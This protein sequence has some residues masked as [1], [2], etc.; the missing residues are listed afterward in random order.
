MYLMDQQGNTGSRAVNEIASTRLADVVTAYRIL[1]NEGVLDGFGHISVR[2]SGGPG[3]FWMPRAMPP[4]LVEVDDFL[5]LDVATSQP[6]DAKGRRVNGERYLHGEIFKAR[7][8]VNAIV[9]A[10]SYATIP[11]TLAGIAMQPVM[12][13][14]GFM[15]LTVP[16][17]ELRTMRGEGKGLQI[18]DPARGAALAAVLG[19]HPV[20][21]LRG[22]GVVVVGP[23]IVHAT[24][25]SIYTEINARLQ[26]QA[27]QMATRVETL[28][29]PELFEPNG[30]DVNRPWQ[31]YRSRLPGPAALA[32][33]DRTQ[34]GLESTQPR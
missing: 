27:L 23:S 28:D 2:A 21:L 5:E 15:P 6:V 1:V 13:Q 9:H 31:H 29:E 32:S 24:V 34:F 10:H 26:A 4:S 19:P 30:F 17:F 14:A 16:T 33:V 22:H 12:V 11:L 18:T 25:Y 7:P 3:R 20:A 8:D